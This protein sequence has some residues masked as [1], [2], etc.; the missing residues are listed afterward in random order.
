MDFTG[1]PNNVPEDIFEHPRHTVREIINGTMVE[2]VTG[3]P[4]LAIM[5]GLT[6]TGPDNRENPWAEAVL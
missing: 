1:W 6:K 4:P 3:S 5:A 2:V